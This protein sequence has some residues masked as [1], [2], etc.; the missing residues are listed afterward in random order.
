MDQYFGYSPPTYGGSKKPGATNMPLYSNNNLYS[1]N[2]NGYR[3]K[4]DD[5]DTMEDDYGVNTRYNNGQDVL[6]QEMGDPLHDHAV[7]VDDQHHD[8]VD[9]DIEIDD[10][11]GDCM[12]NDKNVDKKKK[13]LNM[14]PISTGPLNRSYLALTNGECKEEL[15]S[16][17]TNGTKKK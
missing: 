5:D 6:A 17:D 10:N 2:N 4:Y 15:S 9:T 13:R 16:G 11:S 14:S 3:T 1:S 12:I 8:Q 7:D